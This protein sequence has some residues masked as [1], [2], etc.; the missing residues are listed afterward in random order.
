MKKLVYIN[1]TISL[2]FASNFISSMEKEDKL[3]IVEE[4]K[5]SD[6][7]SSSLSIYLKTIVNRNAS[8]EYEIK[9]SPPGYKGSFDDNNFDN[10]SYRNLWEGVD[11]DDYYYDNFIR[12]H[13]PMTSI[14][15]NVMAQSVR[16]CKTKLKITNGEVDLWTPDIIEKKNTYS[17][18]LA[19]KETN[20][21]TN[22]NRNKFLIFV[23][24]CFPELKS[25]IIKPY[26]IND[27]QKEIGFITF[28]RATAPYNPTKE[29]RIGLSLCFNSNDEFQ[30]KTEHWKK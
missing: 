17:V 4:W 28:D 29:L 23:L 8:T 9:Q 21:W 5:N 13:E 10:K 12:I 18:I 14:S 20:T 16:K 22:K 25:W 27:Q 15:G 6:Q 2:I 11:S 1:L 26:C 3:N 19:L 24:S 30:G 7:G